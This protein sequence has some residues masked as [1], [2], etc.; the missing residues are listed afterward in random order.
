MTGTRSGRPPHDDQLTPAEWAVVEFVRHGLT[1]RQI[2]ERRGVSLDAVKFHVANALGKLGM[3]SRA[4][5]RRWDGIRRDSALGGKERTMAGD[6][7]LGPIGQVARTASDIA[8]AEAWYR[9]VLGLPHL[10][11]FGELAFFDCGGTRLYLQQ[12]QPGPESILYFR[13]GDIHAAHG[14]LAARGAEFVSAP[15]MIHLHADGTEEWMAF[16]NDPDGRPLALMAQA[17]ASAG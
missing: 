4:E 11:T 10:F 6:A 7:K 1:N 15:H 9:D 16:F 2:A 14:E 8:A 3:A 5:L 12:G 13:V 17:A